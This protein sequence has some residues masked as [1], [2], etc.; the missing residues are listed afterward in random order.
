LL[1]R[2]DGHEAL[3]EFVKAIGQKNVPMQGFGTELGQDEDLA[4]A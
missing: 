2:E 1:G 4:Q 3:G